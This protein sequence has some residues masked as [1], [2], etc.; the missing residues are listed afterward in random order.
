M[1]QLPLAGRQCPRT[2]VP[3]LCG[4]WHWAVP[5]CTTRCKFSVL[6]GGPGGFA[7]PP[8]PRLRRRKW[9][10]CASLQRSTK[11]KELKNRRAMQNLMLCKTLRARST[12]PA[13]AGSPGAHRIPSVGVVS[14][15]LL[16]LGCLEDLSTVP[17]VWSHTCRGWN[18]RPDI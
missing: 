13:C 9:H 1:V 18:R 17:Q 11:S 10:G 14:W 8:P 16:E 6:Q 4:S 12:C 15:I 5:S 2:Q 3:D 7:V